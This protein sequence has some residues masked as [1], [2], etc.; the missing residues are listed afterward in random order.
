MIGEPS[1]GRKLFKKKFDGMIYIGT[2]Y[3]EEEEEM[4]MHSSP[5][6]PISIQM[7][8]S[9]QPELGKSSD[10]KK[11]EETTQNVDEKEKEIK[12]NLPKNQEE[13][14]SKRNEIT[15]NTSTKTLNKKMNGTNMKK[16]GENKK[17]K[18]S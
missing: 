4:C 17:M 16:S 14:L 5:D 1:M 11:S 3:E 15:K 9:S 10:T 13:N 7:V 12:I 8:S 18:T 6:I 2:S